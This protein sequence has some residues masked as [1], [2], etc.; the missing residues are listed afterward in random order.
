[1]SLLAELT[2]LRCAYERGQAQMQLSESNFLQSQ[3][4]ARPAGNKCVATHFPVIP[5][6]RIF[7]GTCECNVKEMRLKLL[8]SAWGMYVI[9]CN[10]GVCVCVCESVCLRDIAPGYFKLVRPLI[11]Y[12][13]VLTCHSLDGSIH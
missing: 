11:H 1:M 9:C 13:H 6:K 7:I 4:K 3:H 10:L 5:C 2:S 12:K 8:L